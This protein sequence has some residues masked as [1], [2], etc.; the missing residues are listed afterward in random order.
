MSQV[1]EEIEN[2]IDV[3]GLIEEVVLVKDGA[4]ILYRSLIDVFVDG[5]DRRWWWE[6]FSS[7]SE[8]IT[9]NDG[10][11]FERLLQ[12]VPDINELVWF[13][14]EDDQLPYY[15]IFEAS[16]KNIVK[17]IGECFA[18]EYYLVPK[19]KSW[20]LCENHHNRIIGVGNKVVL[21]IQRASM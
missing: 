10:K 11:G 1:L 5:G 15:P 8:S 18:F 17:V 16:T 4:D 19:D 3:L 13:V 14:V 7:P 20:L 21:S 2:A 6:A 9:I 12:L